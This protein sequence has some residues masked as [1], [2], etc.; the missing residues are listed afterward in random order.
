MGEIYRLYTEVDYDATTKVTGSGQSQSWDAASLLGGGG[1]G[2]I[3]FTLANANGVYTKKAFTGITSNYCFYRYYQSHDDLSLPSNAKY[4]YTMSLLATGGFNSRLFVQNI[5]GTVKMFHRMANDS[6]SNSD[7]SVTLAGAN[8]VLIEVRC[9]KA[10]D[11]STPDGYQELWVNGAL[12]STIS[13]VLLYDRFNFY[14]VH[15]GPTQSNGATGDLYIGK[16]LI[17]DDANPIGPIVLNTGR[18]YDLDQLTDLTT[19]RM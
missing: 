19:I 16:L 6:G 14:E 13:S 8:N 12:V 1:S 5:S 17:T 18:P 10:S 2:D 7:A 4:S 15:I 11:N 9:F 3:K